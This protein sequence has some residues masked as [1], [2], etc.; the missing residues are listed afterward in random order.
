[1]QVNLFQIYQWLKLLNEHVS[2]LNSQI[3][4]GARKLVNDWILWVHKQ[5]LPPP[6]PKKEEKEGQTQ[7]PTETAQEQPAPIPPKYAV[8][9]GMDMKRKYDALFAF[10]IM[11]QQDIEGGM[12]DDQLKEKYVFNESFP[13][14]GEAVSFEVYPAKMSMR[15]GFAIIN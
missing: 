9:N 5:F 15:L 3:N 13:V 10:L 8:F 2:S 1:M 7:A 4:Y 12:N 6:P 14:H 11:I